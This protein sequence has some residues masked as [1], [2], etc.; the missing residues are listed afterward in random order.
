MVLV[1]TISPS[2]DNLVPFV[3]GI[4]RTSS[5]RATLLLIGAC[6]KTQASLKISVK[7]LSCG[8]VG[9]G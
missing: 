3:N 7:N 2:F 9:K 8:S 6:R 4:L 1:S 5:E